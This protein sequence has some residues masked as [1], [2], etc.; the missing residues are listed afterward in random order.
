M[1]RDIELKDARGGRE[2]WQNITHF[3]NVSVYDVTDIAE[4]ANSA[5]ELARKLS[6]LLGFQFTVDRETN[7][8]VRLV[9][10]VLFNL[11]YIIAYKA[12]ITPS[13]IGVR[14]M[15]DNGVWKLVRG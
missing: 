3:N 11:K 13:D 14:L 7:T 5:T 6:D 15:C 10:Q 9:A 12:D 4:D 8:Y 2:A 1:Y